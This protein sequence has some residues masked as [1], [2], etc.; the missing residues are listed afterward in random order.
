VPLFD[1]VADAVRGLAPPKLGACHCTN[2]RY[3]VKVWF[4]GE[5]PTRQHYEAQVI[6]PEHAPPAK[7]LALEVGFHTEHP[8]EADNEDVL[9]QLLRS[10]RKWRRA[11][12][13][14]PV[15]GT[16]LGRA[17]HWRR[18]SEVWPDPDLSDPDLV[19]ELA[20]RLI[21]YMSSLEPYVSTLK[22]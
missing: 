22:T 14:E 13:E 16:F 15:A 8:K 3:G 4:G 18:I 7:V 20:T 2:H 12:G 6:G 9:S 21:D 11:L 19:F 5:K 1:D 10:E 17:D